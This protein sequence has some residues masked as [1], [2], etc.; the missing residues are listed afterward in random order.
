MLVRI[1]FN[2]DCVMSMFAIYMMLYRVSISRKV[3]EITLLIAILLI[4][5][6]LNPI[7]YENLI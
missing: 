5:I 2:F 7:L 6:D 1:Y 4:E 3:F